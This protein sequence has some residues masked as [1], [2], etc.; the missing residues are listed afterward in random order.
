MNEA[1]SQDFVWGRR[2]KRVYA[3]HVARILPGGRGHI[4]RAP[5]RVLKGIVDRMKRSAT[6]VMVRGTFGM[7]KSASDPS[8]GP[9]GLVRG[10][11][12]LHRGPLNLSGALWSV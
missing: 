1:R 9:F 11:S 2:L 7:F 3:W 6:Y 8:R 4:E 10:P 5:S 12:D